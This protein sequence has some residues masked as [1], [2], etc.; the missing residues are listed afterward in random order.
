MSAPSVVLLKG[1]DPS[2]LGDAVRERVG[3]LVGERDTSL[4]VD[5]HAGDEYEVA[6]LVD[7]AQ[8]PPFLTDDR[9]VVGRD[10]GR[11][12]ADELAPLVA[13]LGDPLPTSHLVLVWEQAGSRRLPKKLADAVK[14]AGGEV[15]DTGA[16]RGKERR[17]WV[18]D[19]IRASPVDLDRS[20]RDAVLDRLGDDVD[21]VGSL[22]DTLVAT[23]GDGATL[24]EGEVA[25]F[26][27]EAGQVPPWELTDAI[28]KGDIAAAIDRLHR[29][30][31]AGEMHP[32]QVMAILHR[33]YRQVLRLEGSGAADDKA[34]AAL[35]GLKGSTFLAKKA[36]G[37]AR[38][39]GHERVAQAFALLS[40]ADLDLR[41]ATALD[42]A[43]VLEVLVA[44]LA[45]LGR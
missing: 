21:R 5:E 37:Q 11:F 9:V 17:D 20:A 31:G 43:T 4:I 32:L 18:L 13:Y 33:H 35:L 23:Y 42:G 14:A 6:A 28:D 34:A 44:R 22:L 26:L 45:R 2:L 29:L 40:G 19:R 1:S 3:A 10:L 15:V 12:D 24:G 36:L 41:G 27:G 7:A 8:T 16:G 38:R 30:M 39:L 25:P